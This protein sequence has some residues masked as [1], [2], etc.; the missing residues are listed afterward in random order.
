MTIEPGGGPA[1][2]PVPELTVEPLSGWQAGRVDEDA[3]GEAKKKST[4]ARFRRKSKGPKG[5]FLLRKAGSS[6]S[7]TPP[8]WVG[9]WSL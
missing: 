2:P 8:S 1:A 9:W 7:L 5:W 3:G 6:V 4:F